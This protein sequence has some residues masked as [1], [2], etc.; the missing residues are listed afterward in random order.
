MQRKQ[1][2]HVYAALLALGLNRIDDTVTPFT[3]AQLSGWVPS[4]P[5]AKTAKLAIDIMARHGY[6][7]I[8][9][10]PNRD[11]RVQI[12]A[13]ADRW[14][15]TP[16][17]AD[18]VQQVVDSCEPFDPRVYGRMAE[19]GTVDPFALRLWNLLRIRRML[20]A[21]EGCSVLVDAGDNAIAARRKAG[22][23]L[24]AWQRAC[25]QAI[26]V[27]TRRVGGFKRYVLQVDV[28]AMPPQVGEGA[29]KA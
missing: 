10:Q 25:P 7:A 27:S 24:L 21:D 5:N 6:V 14:H 11:K 15:L 3:V 9:E 20:T 13:P 2:W 17:G 18:A 1:P 22:E 26:R 16:V 4:Y 29:L 19:P 12:V 28:G 23:L 8:C